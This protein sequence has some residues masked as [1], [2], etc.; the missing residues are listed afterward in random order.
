MRITD[1]LPPNERKEEERLYSELVADGES[2]YEK[3]G[4]E[5]DDED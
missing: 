1:S 4:K 2:F 5:N 3:Y